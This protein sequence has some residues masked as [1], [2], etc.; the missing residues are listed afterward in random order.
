MENYSTTTHVINQSAVTALFK[1]TYM[2]MA[3]ALTVTALTSYFLS[4]SA[5]F[6]AMFLTNSSLMWIAI[7]AELGVVIWLSARLHAMSMTM[8]TILFIAYSVLNGVTLSIIFLVYEPEVIAL[9]FAVTAGMFAV[10]SIIG[11]TTRM[12]L[13]KV[14]G[15]LL[16]ALVGI[17]LASVVNIFLGSETL[18]WVITYIGVLVFVGLTA[19]DTN[20]LRQIY[21][22][23][24]EV[25]ETGHKLALMGALTLYLDFINLFLYLLR[26]FGNR[27]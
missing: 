6:L 21:T 20:K 17:I 9:T 10:M 5:A 18:Y 27:R 26:I 14:G 4:Q 15:I 13:S 7:I 22:Q 16:M 8:A 12:D 24:G 11:Y 23:Y 2:Q 1:S 3:A 19:Y 25:N